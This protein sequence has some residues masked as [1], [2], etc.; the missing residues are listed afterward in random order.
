MATNEP[1]LTLEKNLSK[2]QLVKY[3]M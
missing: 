1:D 3:S 2:C